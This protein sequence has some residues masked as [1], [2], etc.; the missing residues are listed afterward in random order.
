MFHVKHGRRTDPTPGPSQPRRETPGEASAYHPRQ[1]RTPSRHPM[2]PN[3]AI[4]GGQPATNRGRSPRPYAVHA[5]SAGRPGH[6]TQS[7]HTGLQHPAPTGTVCVGAKE[8]S[9]RGEPPRGAWAWGGGDRMGRPS[10]KDGG[11]TRGPQPVPPCGPTGLPGR[12]AVMFHVKHYPRR[13]G[14]LRDG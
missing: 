13:T 14:R 8:S 5:R 1:K 4:P 9:P 6:L 3:P 11:R 10:G 12:L 7:S 2:A